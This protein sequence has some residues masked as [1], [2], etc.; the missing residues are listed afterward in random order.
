MQCHRS[1]NYIA[2]MM[3]TKYGMPW[4]KVNFIGIDSTS[5]SLRQMAQCF[6]D[7][8]L[9]KQLA[10]LDAEQLALQ[11]A[12]RRMA[13]PGEVVVERLQETAS[14]A[15]TIRARRTQTQR[16]RDELADEIRARLHAL[17][18]ADRGVR[19]LEKLRE[20][21]NDRCRLEEERQQAKQLDEAALRPQTTV[22]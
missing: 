9:V 16:R 14:C 18:E 5:Q 7:E 17:V 15:A 21:Q 2:E 10:R 1:I 11:D 3:E 20:R 22:L 13:G 6:G 8:E 19:V 12:G 4:L